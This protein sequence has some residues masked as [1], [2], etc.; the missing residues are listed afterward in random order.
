MI[1]MMASVTSMIVMMMVKI[2]EM[3]MMTVYMITA[4]SRKSI[5]R[6]VLWV[7]VVA[8]IRVAWFYHNISLNIRRLLRRQSPSSIR[9]SSR[10][11]NPNRISS[12]CRS[13]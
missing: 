5:K 1:P 11:R 13:N 6:I 2:S 4:H 8:E 12:N 10:K 7:V 9:S 3:A